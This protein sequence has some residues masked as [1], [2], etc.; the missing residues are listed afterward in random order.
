LGDC[1]PNRM[2]IPALVA[3]ALF[4]T[5]AAAGCINI[6]EHFSSD[7]Q[8]DISD[9]GC[10]RLEISFTREF[11]F[12]DV[13]ASAKPGSWKSY[14]FEKECAITASDPK[15]GDPSVISCHPNGRTPLAG[16]TYKLRPT[17]KYMKFD[18]CGEKLE[19]G[20]KVEIW[21]YVCVS[22]CKKGVPRTLAQKD[23]CD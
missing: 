14:P 2:N 15:R 3:F 11:I 23:V 17:G 9:G 4:S 7:L 22:G 16:A 18:A 6:A 10:G 20:M 13:G 1:I 12:N 8:L 21:Q 19:K 5:S